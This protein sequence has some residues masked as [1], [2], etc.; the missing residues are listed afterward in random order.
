MDSYIAYINTDYYYVGNEKQYDEGNG[1][2]IGDKLIT[3]AHV[4]V[5]TEGF[6]VKGKD[7]QKS[8]AICNRLTYTNCKN[9]IR[10]L[11]NNRLGWNYDDFSLFEGN[12]SSS[13]LTLSPYLPLVNEELKAYSIKYEIVQHSSNN[14]NSIFGKTTE[15]RFIPFESTAKVL[16]IR[17]N[18]IFCEM[19]GM[20]EKGRSGCPLIKNNKVFGILRGGDGEKI[21]WFQSSVSIINRLKQLGIPI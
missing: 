7:Y 15:Q 8:S 9:R 18:F 13:P 3:A 6:R 11:S 14:N 20:L 2:F 4:I 10:V 12:G 21:C 1:V 19:N 16:Y 17:G 5:N